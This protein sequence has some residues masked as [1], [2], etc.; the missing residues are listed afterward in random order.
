MLQIASKTFLRTQSD[1]RLAALAAAGNEVAFAAIVER[2]SRLLAGACRRVLPEARVEDAVQQAFMAAWSAL[3]RGDDV[4]ELRP[5]LLR[6]ARNTALNALRVTGYDYDI[7]RDSLQAA[8]APPAELERREVIRSTLAGLAALPESQREA[9][10]GSAVHGTPHA[11]IARE[12]GVSEGAVRQLVLRARM[13][14][15]AAASAVVPLPAVKWLAAAGQHGEPSTARIA[16]LA[17]GAAPVGAGVAAGLAKTSAV[18]AIAGGAAVTP[19]LVERVDRHRN[20]APVAPAVVERSGAANEPAGEAHAS[21]TDASASA[22]LRPS[23]V[24]ASRGG[25]GP[26]P[27]E[28]REGDEERDDDG[29]RAR[30]RAQ[31]ERDEDGYG[32]VVRRGGTASADRDEVDELAD[33]AGSGEQQEGAEPPTVAPAPAGAAAP[34][35]APGPPVPQPAVA[36]S[37]PDEPAETQSE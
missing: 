27:R 12:L 37:E 36:P 4:R 31:R 7:L 25:D 1:A 16:E 33:D 30:R 5:W 24:R 8:E 6:I 32:E 3:R 35:A 2:H 9:L 29:R 11:D 14:L 22:P 20:R 34:T 19:A 17:A 15:R 18:V 26:G 28:D 10:L 13:T 21:H 23:F